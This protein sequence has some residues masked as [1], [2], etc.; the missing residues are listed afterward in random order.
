MNLLKQL[1]LVPLLLLTLLLLVGGAVMAQDAY[2]ESPALAERVAS[3]D[4]PPVAER[5]PAN[6]PVVEPVAEVGQYGGTW[7]LLDTNN[8]LGQLQM[9]IAVEPF[10]KS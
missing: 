10:L 5:L 8:D 2:N 1:T 7:H 3:G 6:P 4:L 9:S